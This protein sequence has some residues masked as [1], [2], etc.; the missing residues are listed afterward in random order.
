M[1]VPGCWYRQLSGF[2][3]SQVS[4]SGVCG[5]DDPGSLAARQV[6]VNYTYCSR[7]VRAPHTVVLV[8]F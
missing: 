4:K 5:Q 6:E 2:K 3:S 1:R 8:H 7:S